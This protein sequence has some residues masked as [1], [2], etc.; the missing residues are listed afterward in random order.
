MQSCPTRSR[1]INRNS[2]PCL[3]NT[4]PAVWAGFMPTPSSV[5]IAEVAG[6]TLNCK[7]KI[8]PMNTKQIN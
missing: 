5:I 8:P 6:D 4:S 1:G 2:Q 3:R 7:L